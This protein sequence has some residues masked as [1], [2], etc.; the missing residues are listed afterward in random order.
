MSYNV[1]PQLTGIT[2]NLKKRPTWNTT[3][4]LTAGGNEFRTG[5]RQNPLTEF[6]L[7]YSYLS[8]TDMLSMEGFFNG[9]NGALTP[10]YFDL[11]VATNAPSDN[12]V[13]AYQFGTGDGSTTA[14]TLIK[15][16]G[17]GAVEPI[18][19]VNG[20][21]L[22]YKSDWQGNQLQYS[23]PRTN[24][25]TNSLA[26]SAWV[27]V[28]AT[29]AAGTAKAP[30]GTDYLSVIT[31]TAAGNSSISGLTVMPGNI[32]TISVIAYPGTSN[33]L[34]MLAGTA[35]PNACAGSIFNLSGSGTVVSVVAGAQGANPSASITARTDGTYRCS[36]TF[37]SLISEVSLGCGVGVSDGSTYTSNTLPSAASGTIQASYL[38]G[39]SGNTLTSFIPTTT[40]PVTVT[41]YT[42]TGNQVAFAVAPLLNAILT[43]TGNFYYLVRFSEDVLE[44]NQLMNQ[45]YE[46]QECKLV[47]VR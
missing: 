13:T 19:G 14:F 16:A 27:N 33:Y 37:T 20:S 34:G 31:A 43:W 25:I 4:M 32:Y 29:V 6:D 15:P 22:I 44:F 40:A 28:N 2:W 46:L 21:P 41:D 9:Q 26:P 3:K 36:L 30:D 8:P 47:S 24:S 42:L 35:T 12:S 10:F 39:E 45:M 1:F 18:G 23:T 7:S 11:G 38:Q 5:Y 17:T